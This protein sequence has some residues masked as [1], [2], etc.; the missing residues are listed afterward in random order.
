MRRAKIVC[1]IGPATSSP[2]QLRELVDDECEVV[3]VVQLPDAFD[4]RYSFGI[5]E[6]ASQG[7]AGVRGIGHEPSVGE[8]AHNLVDAARLRILRMHI[9][10]L[11]HVLSLGA[12][13]AR[14]PLLSAIIF[15][16]RPIRVHR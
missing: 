2:E 3:L 8:D 1:T 11:S 9:V 15:L 7:V 6:S 10:V 5:A 12:R 4:P 14:H 13:S 16:S